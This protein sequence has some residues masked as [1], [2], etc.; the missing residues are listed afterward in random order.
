MSGVRLSHHF[1]IVIQKKAIKRVQVSFDS[2][3]ELMETSEPLD[4]DEFLLSFGPH[5]GGEAANE[6]I[7]RLEEIGL[8]YGNDFIDFNDTLPDWCQLFITCIDE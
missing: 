8:Q 7:K 1:G 3:L 2:I 5:F 6:F 4:E